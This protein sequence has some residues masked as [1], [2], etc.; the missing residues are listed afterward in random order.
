MTIK[1]V[2]AAT[3]AALMTVSSVGTAFA[4]NNTTGKNPG[5]GIPEQLVQFDKYATNSLS[6]IHI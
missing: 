6:L 2:S 1:K 5:S 3:L 4:L